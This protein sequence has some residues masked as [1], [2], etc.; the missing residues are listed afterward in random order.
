[1]PASIVVP[2]RA[3]IH[4][5][6][7]LSPSNAEQLIKSKSKDLE[8][9]TQEQLDSYLSLLDTFP[10]LFIDQSIEKLKPLLGVINLF[11]PNPQHILE[12]SLISFKLL[13]LSIITFPHEQ[14]SRYPD[15]NGMSAKDYTDNLPLVKKLP[16]LTTVTETTLFEIDEVIE[17]YSNLLDDD[18]AE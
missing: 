17:G 14:S 9:L 5:S 6:L 8:E 10:K 13:V 2:A 7:I 11:L 16:Q 18:D 15:T 3:G 1:M 4:A 12:Q